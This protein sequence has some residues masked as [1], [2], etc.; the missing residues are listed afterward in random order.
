MG[1]IISVLLLAFTISSSLWGAPTIS[2]VSGTVSHGQ[3]ITISGSGFGTK[4]TAA[5]T[6][7]D[8]CSGTDTSVM[9]SGAWPTVVN[10]ATY[11]ATYRTPATVGRNVSLPHTHVSKYLCGANYQT[12]DEGGRA[13]SGNNVMVWKT[14]TQGTFP[15]Y[16]Y[17]SYYEQRDPNFDF[18]QD[19]TDDNYKTW[20]YSRGGTPYGGDYSMDYN[21]YLEDFD[22]GE[23]H[24][25]DDGSAGITSPPPS[26]VWGGP[27]AQSGWGKVEI[28]I[29][30]T[31]QASGYIKVWENGVL[32]LDYS[33]PTDTM[34][35]TDR[36]ECVGGY[37]RDRGTGNWRYWN[38]IYLDNT[39]QRVLIGNANTLAGCTTLREVQI[40]SAWTDTSI[41]ATVNQGG[42]ADEATAYLYVFDATGTANS[43]GYS[44]TFGEESS[45]PTLSNVTISNG[46]FR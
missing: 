25:V 20:D 7:W 43:T 17:C 35:G 22:T 37:A 29:C 4:S 45:A 26:S 33:G 28:E 27:Y 1:K 18:T 41:T 11:G 12:W 8:D 32:D 9:W 13:D 2:G 14:R 31:D 39:R 21:W 10:S 15:Q 46:S 36:S 24:I 23:W 42:F 19:A 34:P 6:I 40:P 44:I 5:P 30:Y 38:D 16:T 3:S